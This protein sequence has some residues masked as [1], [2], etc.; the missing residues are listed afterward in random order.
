MGFRRNEFDVTDQV[1]IADTESVA[2]EVVNIYRTLHDGRR[3]QL[4]LHAFDL[5]DRMYCGRHP[6]YF[7]CDTWYHDLQHSLDVTLAMAR[8]LDGFERSAPDRLRLGE[9]MFVLGIIVA[10]F[11]DIGYIRRRKDMRHRYG[12]EYTR[13]HV[14]RGAQFI[15]RYLAGSSLARHAVAGEKI[16]HF[17]GF[18]KAVEAIAL[19]PGP[20][21]I[22][23]NLVGSADIIAQMADRCYLEKCRDRLYPEFALAGIARRRNQPANG[24]LFASSTDLVLKTPGF[25]ALA[26][27]RLDET[28]GG[29]YRH[30]ERHFGGQNLYWEEVE[31]NIRF[32]TQLADANDVGRLKRQLDETAV[33]RLVPVPLDA[34]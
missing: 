30:A 19:P 17:T 29:A 7:P 21:R 10:I 4:F 25:Y 2:A 22:L 31:K 20:Y 1:N 24:A 11:H 27:T 16:V 26:Q 28:L 23:G 18:E 14:S 6:G 32:A 33:T 12:A 3:E 13:I 34:I 15:R 9:E 5:M 8:L